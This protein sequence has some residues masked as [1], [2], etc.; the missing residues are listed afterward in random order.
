MKLN[1]IALTGVLIR[2][3]LIAALIGTGFIVILEP[4]HTENLPILAAFALWYTHLFFIAL[5]FLVGVIALQRFR[6]PD[7][8]PAFVSA[9]ILPAPFALVSLGLDYGFGNA[10]DDM[11]SAD[12][13]FLIFL[14][15]VVAVAP[16]TF[17]VALA[18]IL[19]L[20]WDVLN[21]DALEVEKQSKETS[22][23]LRYLIDNVPHSLGDDIIRAHAQDHYVE[24]VTSKGSALLTEQFGN[25]LEKLNKLDGIQCHRSHWI[26]LAHVDKV[27]R[28]GSAYTCKMSNGDQVPVSRR[29]YSELRDKIDFE[30][31][32]IQR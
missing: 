7:P 4:N 8:I 21:R 24:I 22:P 23:T 5:L 30:T 18:M 20:R 6:C 16:I 13:P 19:I 2:K 17:A 10:T 14:D 28:K 15:E 31:A 11:E 27:A 9:L 29:K 32:A 26:C 25:C 12:T 3:I 1:H